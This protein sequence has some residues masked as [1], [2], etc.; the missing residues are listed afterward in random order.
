[1]FAVTRPNYDV[2]VIEAPQVLR[3]DT[4]GV[5]V[6][7]KAVEVVVV[8]LSLQAAVNDAGNAANGS[9]GRVPGVGTSYGDQVCC[10]LVNIIL[11]AIDLGWKFHQLAY[12]LLELVNL[13]WQ[14]H[15]SDSLGRQEQEVVS[16]QRPQQQDLGF[17][18]GGQIS[19]RCRSGL[20]SPDGL[21]D[22]LGERSPSDV[23]R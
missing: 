19:R 21:F 3:C 16:E 12:V 9:L 20:R 5:V 4:G 8:Q 13:G 22:A 17:G 15:Q 1:M 10:D 18:V 11:E 14:L 7:C 6:G 2:G 23:R